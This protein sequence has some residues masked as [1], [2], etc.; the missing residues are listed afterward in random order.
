M[1]RSQESPFSVSYDLVG[2]LDV[3]CLTLVL[4]AAEL[5]YLVHLETKIKGLI[6]DLTV[7]TRLEYL[8]KL[9]S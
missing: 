2:H 6:S 9:G 4:V 7:K 1:P 5:T 8:A 3:S